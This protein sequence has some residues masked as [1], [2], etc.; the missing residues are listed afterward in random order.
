MLGYE[1]KAFGVGFW[2]RIENRAHVCYLRKG[3][4]IAG[5]AFLFLF[6][7]KYR[8]QMYLSSLCYWF[9]AADRQHK[10]TKRREERG[11]LAEQQQ[12][13]EDER[14]VS[15]ASICGMAFQ[16]LTP[17]FLVLI[18]CSSLSFLVFGPASALL[19]LPLLRQSLLL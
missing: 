2:E 7:L 4:C 11:C 14:F 19:P 9:R 16:L 12:G 15:N 8:I 17:F 18:A 10:R 5:R 1:G 3:I 13:E 6:G